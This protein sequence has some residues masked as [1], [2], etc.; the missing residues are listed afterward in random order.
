MVE[1]PLTVSNLIYVSDVEPGILRQRRGKGFCFRLPCGSIVKDPETLARIRKLG[2]PPAY[3]DVW[4]CLSEHGHLQAT[5]FDARGRKQYRYHPEW[6]SQRSGH[7]FDQ[8]AA[9]GASLPR[10]RRRVARDLATGAENETGILAAVAM[11][12]DLA[13][14]RV[15]NLAYARENNTFGATTL[16]KRHVRILEDRIELKFRAKGGKRVQRTLKHPRLQKS[17]EAIADLPG[18]RL[19][20]WRDAAGSD[21]AIDSGKLNAYLCDATGLTVSAKTFRTWGG[22]VAAFSVAMAAIANEEAPTVKL[23]CAAAAEE[24]HNTPAICRKSYI[25]PKVLDLALPDG[26]AG[27]DALASLLADP[28]D[29]PRGLTRKE[30]LLAA[31]LP[32]EAPATASRAA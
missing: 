31:F 9:F 16:L 1:L 32:N 14:I 13:H 4:I 29:T 30:A 10:F 7:K 2:I 3:R 21:H 24:L 17:L 11:L 26:V 8:L 12:L 27:R 23:L 5:G 28:P 6:Q 22:S 19:F 20:A 18:R 15:G 25:H